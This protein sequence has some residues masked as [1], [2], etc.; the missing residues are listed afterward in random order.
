MLILQSILKNQGMHASYQYK[1]LERKWTFATFYLCSQSQFRNLKESLPQLQI[2]SLLKEKALRNCISA[3]QQAQ[4]FPCP[5]TSNLQLLKLL[6][7]DIFHPSATS[8][9]HFWKK[10]GS[11][12]T[13]G[14]CPTR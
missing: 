6:G 8:S 4:F 5:T 2:N 12:V 13:I 9:L 1:C 3:Y 7:T 10:C 11:V 14:G